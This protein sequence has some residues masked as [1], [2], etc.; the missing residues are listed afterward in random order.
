MYLFSILAFLIL[1]TACR[2]PTGPS[3]NPLHVDWEQTYGGS[4]WDEAKSVIEVAGGNFILAGLTYSFGAGKS[5]IFLIKTNSIG[6]S[7]WTKTYGDTGPDFA[8]SVVETQDGGFI[9]AGGTSLSELQDSDAYLVR[10]DS[11]GNI[12][13]E[14]KYGRAT[15]D[16]AYSVQQTPD[17]GFI[18]TGS[19]GSNIYLIRTDQNGDTLWTKEYARSTGGV[20]SSIQPTTDGGYIIAG[21]TVTYLDMYLL[22]TDA[23]GDSLWAHRYGPEDARNLASSA[24]ETPDGGYIITGSTMSNDD[25]NTDVYLIKTNGNG[26]VEWTKK[27]GGQEKWGSG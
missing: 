21:Y 25:G 15:K 7:I 12:L 13:W 18:V 3:S 5:D 2:K 24:K 6:D 27:F 8:E 14:K 26:D 19:S 4:D 1:Q 10:T 9:I 16:C 17:G 22:K 11:D 20:G 23:N